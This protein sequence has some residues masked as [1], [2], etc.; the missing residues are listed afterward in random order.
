MQKSHIQFSDNKV[1][2]FF[3]FANIITLA[4]KHKVIQRKPK[5]ITPANFILSHWQLASKNIFSY[6]NWAVQLGLL[7]NQKV[8]GQAIW[9]RLNRNM[10]KLVKDL[11]QKSFIQ[12]QKDFIE[13]RLFNPFNQVHIQDATHFKLPS[14]L[15]KLFP[16]SHS[17]YRKTATAKIQ[18]TF[19]LKKGVFSS[20]T[21]NSYRDNDQKDSPRI[22]ELLREN[23]LIIR[24]LGYFVLDVFRKIIAK[25]AFFLS[26]LKPNVEI[27]SPTTLKPINIPSM[28]KNQKRGIDIPV[29][30]GK[31]EKIACRL[32]VLPVPE[33][34]ANERRRKAQKDRNKQANHSK[35][36]LEMLSYTL[37][38]TN[39]EK[40]VWST[41]DVFK[42][43]QSRWYIEII[44]KAWK[45]HLHIQNII[46]EKYINEIRAEYLF[47]SYLL[48]INV[49][50][51][52]F[53]KMVSEKAIK[54]N[55]YVSIIKICDFVS[56]NITAFLSNNNIELLIESAKYFCQYDSRKDRINAIQFLY[57]S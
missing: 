28:M 39:V 56:K 14:V 25:K 6:D 12:K 36:Y 50:V 43:Y 41:T 5:K 7:T 54:E 19:N 44:F 1:K 52:P 3:K 15:H 4:K 55:K 10:V 26:R 48:M 33:E 18:A 22:V 37:Y 51:N 2:T 8:S 34:V 42:A 23:D 20:F 57:L 13:T 40:E 49:L 27:L 47:Y 35:K 53:F 46:P 45:S 17:P 31:K 16:G 38:I 32:I 30:L 29:L 9:K 21:L 24:D 11:L